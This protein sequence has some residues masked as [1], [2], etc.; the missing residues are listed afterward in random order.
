MQLLNKLGTTLKMVFT[1]HAKYCDVKDN[2]DLVSVKELEFIEKFV[3][4]N[5]DK[6]VSYKGIK[7]P[8]YTKLTIGQFTSIAN[9]GENSKPEIILSILT[10]FDNFEEGVI[11]WENAPAYIVL[12][13]VTFFLSILK[14]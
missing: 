13:N 3:K 10:H 8:H 7:P 14:S 4:A 1:K 12:N 5:S 2:P 11:F 9:L 6:Y